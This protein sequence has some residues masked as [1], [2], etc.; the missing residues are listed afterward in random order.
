MAARGRKQRLPQA[1]AFSTPLPGVR[2]HTRGAWV[3][4]LLMLLSPSVQ[5]GLWAS[6]LAWLALTV[7][8]FLR[9]H[10]SCRQEDL[11][12]SLLHEKELLLARSASRTSFQ[13]EK[14]AAI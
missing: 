13:G 11:L 14:S 6:W 5:L 7:L 3:C 2:G 12:D 1:R 4:Q 9:V 8:A 10:H